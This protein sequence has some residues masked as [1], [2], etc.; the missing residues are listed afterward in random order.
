MQNANMPIENPP[1]N[2]P[3][4]YCDRDL[5]TILRFLAVCQTKAEAGLEKS[6]PAD[7]S[8]LTHP[9]I[10]NQMNYWRNVASAAKWFA[11]LACQR[12]V[13]LGIDDDTDLDLQVQTWLKE[14]G[15][16]LNPGQSPTCASTTTE[17]VA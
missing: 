8:L 6:T 15:S 14:S 3:L 16:L 2:E 10:K 5:T 1:A 4:R 13:H 12:Q 7:K 9:M 11:Y 17:T